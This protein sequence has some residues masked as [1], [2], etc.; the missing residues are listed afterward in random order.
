MLTFDRVHI[1]GLDAA[2]LITPAVESA[3]CDELRARLQHIR[4]T[5]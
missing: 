3:L 5:E 4:D 2:G 1:R